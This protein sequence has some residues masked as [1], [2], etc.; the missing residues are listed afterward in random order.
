MKS[1]ID[2]RRDRPA[3]QRTT[4]SLPTGTP[5]RSATKKSLCVPAGYRRTCRFAVLDARSCGD[6]RV[7]EEY[8]P[9]CSCGD[10]TCSRCVPDCRV[11][12]TSCGDEQPCGEDGI[13]VPLDCTMMGVSC[14]ASADC[15]PDAAGADDLG[16]VRRS[17]SGDGDCDCGACVFNRCHD[18][19]GHC[20]PP[21]A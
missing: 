19:P 6:G 4:I 13:C 16:C 2:G 15:D 18:G 14:P 9:T 20:S 7:C 3:L 5:I 21:A 17:C 10:G 8:L 1:P 11:D 12:P